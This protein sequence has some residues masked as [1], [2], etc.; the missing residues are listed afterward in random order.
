MIMILINSLLLLLRH[1]GNPPS[2]LAFPLM[3]MLHD[4]R[5]ED[6]QDFEFSGV[7]G[8]AFMIPLNHF[9]QLVRSYYLDY[10][11]YYT[12]T[13]ADTRGMQQTALLPT[14]GEESIYG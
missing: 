4:G 8:V 9:I 5:R 3:G 13:S 2:T 14:P 1:D 10:F 7:A 11:Y 6:P 12:L